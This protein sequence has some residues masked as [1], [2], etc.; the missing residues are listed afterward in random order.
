M[1]ERPIFLNADEGTWREAPGERFLSKLTGED[2]GGKLA[3]A[4]T[5]RE[6][7]AGNQF[8]RHMKS[9]EMWYILEGRVVIDVDDQSQ[10]LGP[11]GL[12]FAPPGSLHRVTNL[13]EEPVKSVALCSPAGPVRRT[14]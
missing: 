13:G 14:S 9:G 2:T 5:E 11:G 7:W 4:A 8:H 6:P 12:A 1:A 10:E 3:F